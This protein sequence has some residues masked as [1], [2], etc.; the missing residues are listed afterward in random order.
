MKAMA[1]EPVRTPSS[2]AGILGFYDTTTGG[3]AL[4]PRAVLA[5]SILFVVTIKILSMIKHA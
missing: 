3:P 4:D 5:F 2:M 1:G